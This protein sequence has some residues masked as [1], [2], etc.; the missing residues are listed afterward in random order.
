MATTARRGVILLP[1]LVLLALGT[2]I[3]G[4]NEAKIKHG[5]AALVRSTYRNGLCEG[6][7]VYFSPPRGTLLV[8]CGIPNSNLTGGLIYRVAENY[9]HIFLEEG[10]EVT[11]FSARQVYWDNVISRDSYLPLALFPNIYRRVK[12]CYTDF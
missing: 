1:L 8:L 2:I 10:Y 9:G 6:V 11:V 5:E 3:I 4:A 7:E 12:E